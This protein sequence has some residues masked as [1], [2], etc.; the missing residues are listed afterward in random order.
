MRI[1]TPFFIKF[2]I[3]TLFFTIWKMSIFYP[4]IFFLELGTKK[5]EIS[6]NDQRKFPGLHLGLE[7]NLVTIGK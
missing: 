5:R 4:S 6:T 2:L 7:I 1:W 3:K